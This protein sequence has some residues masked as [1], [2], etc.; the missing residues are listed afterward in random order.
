MSMGRRQNRQSPLWIAHDEIAQGPGHRFY[1]KLNELLR[2]AAFDRHAEALCAPYYEAAHV[3]GRQSVAPGIYFRMHLVGFFEGIES[4]R[5]LEW[6]F[7]DSLSLRQFLGLSLTQRVPDHSTL[8]RTRQR[9][10]LAVHQAVFALILGIVET[11]GLLHGRVLGV[12]S[13]YLRADASMKAIVRRDT[14]E[15]YTAFVTRL[16]T[17]AGIEHP[18]AEEARRL[19]RKRQGKKTSNREWVSRTD[20]DARIAK[21]TDGRTR[22][23]YKP[24]HVVDLETGAILAAVVHGADVAD[25]ASVEA[26]LTQAEANLQTVRGGAPEAAPQ[27]NPSPHG[28]RP[29]RKVVADKG[30]HKATLLRRLKTQQYRTYIPERRQAGRRRWTDK[31]GTPTAVAF[32][33]NRA[34]GMRPL[35]KRYHRWRAERVERTFAHVC[36]T[37]GARRTRLRGRANV[38]KRYLLQAAGA[39]LALVMRTLFGLG[40]PRGWAQRAQAALRAVWGSVRALWHRWWAPLRSRVTFSRALVAWWP[41]RAE[42]IS[43]SARL[44]ARP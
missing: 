25:P 5:G 33:Q 32:H 27:D 28:R 4:E 38:E 39:N 11:K 41:S 18:T 29:R 3:P 13:T 40:T 7:A 37:G 17:E 22:L 12:D 10:P 24:E 9:L 15:S 2:D 43:W 8:S 14:R 36:E 16:A 31:G 23:A 6:R 20:R 26:S 34:R 1:E 21:L 35:G 30:Y 42:L 19:D 44:L